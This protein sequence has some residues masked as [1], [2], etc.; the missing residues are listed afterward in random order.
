MS[1]ASASTNASQFATKSTVS[2][3]ESAAKACEHCGLPCENGSFAIGAKIFCCRGCQTVFEL[4]TG[5]GLI[6]YYQLGKSAGM[7]FRRPE[8]NDDFSYLDHP[9]VSERLVQFSSDRL[10]R[11]TFRLPAIHCIACVWLLENLPRLNPAI[12]QTQVNFGR[13]ELAIAFDPSRLKLSE[14]AALLASLGYAPDLNF[15]DLDGRSPSPVGRRLWLRVGLAGFAFGNIMLFSLPGYFGLDRFSDAAFSPMFGWY[16]LLLAVPVLLFSAADYWRS[17]WTGAR[18]GRLTVEV[19]I[20]LGLAALFERSLLDI[21]RGAGV[22]FL[23]TLT[24]LTFFLLIGRVF[25]QKTYERLSFERDFR[26][27]FPLAVTRKRGTVAEPLNGQTEEKIGLAQLAVGDHLIIRNGELIPADSRLLSGPALIDYSFVTGESEPVSREG[28]SHLYAGGRQMGGAIEIVTV[29][30]V[31]QGY[32]TALWNQAAFSKGKEAGFDSLTNR[33]SQGFTLGI[34][35]IAVIAG[36][37]WWIAGNP[38]RALNSFASVL[39]VACPCAL[40]LA[41]PFA[42]GTALRMLGRRRIFLKAPSVIENLARVDTVVFDKTGTLTVAGRE[43]VKFVGSPLDPAEACEL[44]SLTRHS[45][46]PYAVRICESLARDRFPEEVRGF[47]ETSGKGIE[48]RI[49]GKEIWLGSG[50]WLAGRGVKLGK[51]SCSTLGSEVHVAVNGSYRGRFVLVG[52]V[53][54][55]A[56]RMLRELSQC[57]RLVLLSG[58]N[59]RENEQF[60]ELLGPDATLRFNQS[61]LD[62]L[63]FI[64]GLERNGRQVLMVGDGLNDAGALK[65]STVGLAVVEDIGAF[66]PASDGIIAA[67]RVAALAGILRFSRQSVN[68]V[69]AGLCLS[70]VYNLAGVT[71]AVRGTLSPIFCAIFMPLSSI[72]VVMVSTGLAAWFARRTLSRDPEVAS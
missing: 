13:K 38:A 37:A 14:V 43:A 18:Q 12:G 2:T 60:A 25:Q 63:E 3:A 30:R 48:A 33:F 68:I 7:A 39:I 6:D 35:T 49:H 65:Q 8:G 47:L 21:Y 10:T 26:S 67:D 29:K 27:F 36:A 51:A 64:H 52:A 31:N 41:A 23:D 50:D 34:L 62:K 19:P 55:Q 42:L 22:G 72:T 45:T 4:L 70:A 53:R 71:L 32:L 1:L 20:A 69:K 59:A 28:G 61:P 44:F 5:N 54:P 40:A 46:H 9:E 17:A 16:A 58:D 15:A 24:G 56:E 11:I 66:S 57:C